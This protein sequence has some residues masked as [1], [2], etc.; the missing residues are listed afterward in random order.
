MDHYEVFAMLQ[1]IGW[2][3]LTRFDREQG[4]GPDE[5]LYAI[6]QDGVVVDFAPAMVLRDLDGEV[7]LMVQRLPHRVLDYFEVRCYVG[8]VSEEPEVFCPAE[9][10]SLRDP[11]RWGSWQ[12]IQH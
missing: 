3:V 2:E 8:G 7:K 10:L 5:G 6:T 12:D 9:M 4:R 1:E 11:L